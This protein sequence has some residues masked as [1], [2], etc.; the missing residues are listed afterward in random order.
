MKKETARKKVVIG[1]C[2]LRLLEFQTADDLNDYLKNLQARKKKF[3]IENRGRMDN[4][5]FRLRIKEQ[6]NNNEMI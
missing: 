4:G 6:Y 5:K 3:E 1:A 2:I